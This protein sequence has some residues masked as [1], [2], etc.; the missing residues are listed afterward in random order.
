V[1]EVE[2]TVSADAAVGGSHALK[3]RLRRPG[4]G[5][6]LRSEARQELDDF[7]HGKQWVIMI[8]V[9]PSAQDQLL[10]LRMAPALGVVKRPGQE[11]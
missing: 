2:T 5:T 3:R 11:R 8:V 7:I 10:P 4:E 6:L 9:H 1:V